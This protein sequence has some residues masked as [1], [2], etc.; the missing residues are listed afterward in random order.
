MKKKKRTKKLSKKHQR[1]RKQ[2]VKN[3]MISALLC[4]LVLGISYI[5]F[6]TDI[7]Q[8]SVNEVTASYISFNNNDTTDDIK[9]NN[10]RKMSNDIGKS[11]VNT[12]SSDILVSGEDNKEYQVVI[13]PII[14]NIDLKHINYAITIGNNSYDNN[15]A[16]M[17]MRTDEGIVVY[18]GKVNKEK[19]ITI[20]L[21][22][23]KDYEGEVEN[24]SF[25]IKVNPR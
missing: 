16:S 17:T 18:N 11:I 4:L 3:T 25:K 21:W 14:N 13:Y 12:K 10:I 2:L 9:I 5:I 20:R 8:P 1:Q 19:K 22:I 23:S 7:L 15:L 6:E 24:N